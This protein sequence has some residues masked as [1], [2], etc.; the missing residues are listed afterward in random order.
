MYQ[1]PDGRSEN[2]IRP[3]SCEFGTLQNCDG[4]AVWKSGRTSVL[5]AVHGPVAPRQPQYESSTGC[6]VSVVIKSNNNSMSTSSTYNTEWET[7]LTQQLTACIIREL[8]PRCV[9]SVMVQIL[10]D[11]GSVL[12]T[13]LHAAVSAL[14]DATI[15]MKYLPTAVTCFRGY[16][17]GGGFGGGAMGITTTTGSNSVNNNSNS[18]TPTTRMSAICL[19][20]TFDEEQSASA[21]LVLVFVPKHVNN[22]KHDED[23]LFIGCFT[24]TASMRQSTKALIQCGTS[25]SSAVPAIQA[26][27][28]LAIEQVTLGTHKR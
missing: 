26:F 7:F 11:D 8:Y 4:S 24:T 12:A 19:D 25:A 27:W 9:I 28:R 18:G 22:N 10:H 14:L 3:L 20:P 21:V 13:A 1:R 6:L 5:V 15:E 23:E 16:N 17:G 2:T